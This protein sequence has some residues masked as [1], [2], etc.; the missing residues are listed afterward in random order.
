MTILIGCDFGCSGIVGEVLFTDGAVPV[1]HVPGHEAG[2]CRCGFFRQ[3]VAAQ[4][5]VLLAAVVADSQCETGS[6]AAVAVRCDGVVGRLCRAAGTGLGVCIVAVGI[7]IAVT[8]AFFREIIALRFMAADVMLTIVAEDA[9]GEAFGDAVCRYGVISVSMFMVRCVK[10]SVRST[11]DTAYRLSNAGGFAAGMILAGVDY[12]VGG[13]F[14]RCDDGLIPC[15]GEV[16]GRGGGFCWN[17]GGDRRFAVRDGLRIQHCGPVFRKE[18]N[19]IGVCRMFRVQG[20]AVAG[21]GIG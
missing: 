2:R 14:R 21:G 17:G 15:A 5:A 19:R 12:R 11:A 18:C 8:V 16:L 1:D 3:S 7:P 20:D 10:L 13:C 6:R 4:H 9:G